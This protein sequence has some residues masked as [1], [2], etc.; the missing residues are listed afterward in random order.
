MCKK[1]CVGL[2][3]NTLCYNLVVMVIFD[4]QYCNHVYYD[5]MYT[6]VNIEVQTNIYTSLIS[7]LLLQ[8]TVQDLLVCK[9]Q[10]QRTVIHTALT[11]TG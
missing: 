5:Q 6:T 9:P 3:F 8:C 7:A 2:H 4:L 1:R 11:G 10:H